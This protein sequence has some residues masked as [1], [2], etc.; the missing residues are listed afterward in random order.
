M[1]AVALFVVMLWIFAYN[2]DVPLF[3]L[4]QFTKTLSPDFEVNNAPNLILPWEK[5][6]PGLGRGTPFDP[7]MCLVFP[8]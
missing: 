1:P 6:T 5:Q 8:V 4:S 3:T 7:S 2:G